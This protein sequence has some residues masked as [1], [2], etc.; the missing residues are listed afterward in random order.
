MVT[1]IIGCQHRFIYGGVKYEDESHPMLGTGARRRNY[2]DW[3]YCEKCTE[4]IYLT[5]NH[6]DDTYQKVQFGA[7][8][9]SR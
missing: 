7:T 2:F 3:F 4:T 8:P 1:N 6:T 5:L 9:K